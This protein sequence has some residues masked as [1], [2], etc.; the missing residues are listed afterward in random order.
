MLYM[1]LSGFLMILGMVQAVRL[2][3]KGEAGNAVNRL[4]LFSAYILPV[5]AA[6]PFVAGFITLDSGRSVAQMDLVSVGSQWVGG[7][8]AL[9]L[10]GVHLQLARKAPKKFLNTGAAVAAA[11]LVFIYANSLIFISGSNTGLVAPF[12]LGDGGSNDVQCERD[13]LLIHYNKGGKSDWR[14]PK[15]IML[16]GD[17]AHPFVP[18]PDYRQGSSRYLTEALDALMEGAKRGKGADQKR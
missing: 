1:L 10:I 17:S 11:V 9:L 7:A 6:A 14:C 13:V 8:A 18:W 5:L 15:S 3:V 4:L 12:I 2:L 16:M